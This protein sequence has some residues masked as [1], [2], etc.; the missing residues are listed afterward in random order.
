MHLK[1][2]AYEAEIIKKHKNSS[3]FIIDMSEMYSLG[4]EAYRD[5]RSTSSI[6]CLCGLPISLTNHTASPRGWGIY[7]YDP[8]FI[9][10][11]FNVR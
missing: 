7:T 8:K 9:I 4:L 3:N 5:M 6:L 11:P 2:D 1:S 10:L